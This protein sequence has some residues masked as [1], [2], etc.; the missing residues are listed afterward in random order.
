MTEPLRL[1]TAH[2]ALWKQV[3]NL[4]EVTGDLHRLT[5]AAPKGDKS[6]DQVR[7]LVRCLD[8]I[9][10][11]MGRALDSIQDDGHGKV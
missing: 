9:A 7:Q 5:L 2:E 8:S 4:E 3:H 6:W 10:D 11:V 1:T